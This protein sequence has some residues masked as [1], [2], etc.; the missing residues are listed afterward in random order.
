MVARMVL[1]VTDQTAESLPQLPFHER[2][3][4]EHRLWR[5]SCVTSPPLDTRPGE[6]VSPPNSAD[7]NSTN[8]VHRKAWSPKPCAPGPKPP[9]ILRPRRQRLL[10]RRRGRLPQRDPH[11]LRG[12]CPVEAVLPE[13]VRHRWAPRPCVSLGASSGRKLS[14][15]RLTQ[16]RHLP[17]AAR[18]A[19]TARRVSSAAITGGGAP[20]PAKASLA[21]KATPATGAAALR[22]WATQGTARGVLAGLPPA[23]LAVLRRVPNAQG[24]HPPSVSPEYATD[25]EREH[26]PV[27]PGRRRMAGGTSGGIVQT[28]LAGGGGGDLPLGEEEEEKRLKAAPRNHL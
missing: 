8:L 27:F 17:P 21:A 15:R 6:T 7:H 23:R 1:V 12:C 5:S 16:R 24:G 4:H 18:A 10:W 26:L 11:P 19:S 3:G 25:I 28:E 14:P 2:R 22:G 13:A 20:T 9:E